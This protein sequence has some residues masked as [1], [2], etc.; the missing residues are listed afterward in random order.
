MDK[1]IFSLRDEIPRTKKLHL[2]PNGEIQYRFLDKYLGF[3][4]HQ[5]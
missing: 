5:I 4:S 1:S 3:Y 2:K